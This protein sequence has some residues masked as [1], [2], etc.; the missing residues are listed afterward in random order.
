PDTLPR[1][2]GVGWCQVHDPTALS[3]SINATNAR[4]II[5][6]RRSAGGARVRLWEPGD[7]PPMPDECAQRYI[8]GLS[9]GVLWRSHQSRCRLLG[10]SVQ[11]LGDAAFG[12]TGHRYVGSLGPYP[13]TPAQQAA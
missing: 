6:P 2:E 3:P 7:P 5:K 4:W 8:T 11:I 12:A 1:I 10:A 9:L 13:L